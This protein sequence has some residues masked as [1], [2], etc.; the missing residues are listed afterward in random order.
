MKRLSKICNYLLVT[1]F[2]YL[3]QFRYALGQGEEA[4]ADEYPLNPSRFWVVI[5]MIISFVVIGVAVKLLYRPR[6]KQ[7]P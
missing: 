1:F 4:H 5:S 2:L 6:K 7:N 3:L